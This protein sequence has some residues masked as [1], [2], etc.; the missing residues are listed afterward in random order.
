MTQSSSTPD[1]DTPAT[2]EA[3][4]Q[5]RKLDLTV[6]VETTGP[7]RRHVKI[8]IAR[9]DV[10]FFRNE[11]LA[12][13]TDKAAV[14]GFRVG[15]VPAQL[16]ER[17]YKKELADQVRQ[18]LVIQTLEQ[19]YESKLIDPIT[20]PEIDLESLLIPDEGEFQFEFDVEV[21]PEFDL[22]DLKGLTIKRPVRKITDADVD[23]SVDQFLMQIATPKIVDENGAVQ[24]DD[25]I[26]CNIV[27]RQGDNVL[28]SSEEVVVAVRPTLQFS[29]AQLNDFDKLMTGAKVGDSRT[30]TVT[31]AM[32]AERIEM[33]GEAVEVV[34]TVSQIVRPSRPE[35]NEE[36]LDEYG[37][38]SVEEL[39]DR[40]RSNLERQLT[41]E[42]RQ[43]ARQQI[44]DQITAAATWDLPEKVVLKQ[45]QNALY[46]EILEMRQ[47]GYS[48][49]E[50]QA[51]E[52]HL[53]QNAVTSTRRA[54]KEHFI[55]DRLA[56]QE[57][58]EVSDI[59]LQSEIEIMARNEGEN[60]RRVR[61][62]LQK[63]GVIENLEAQ[64][65][66]R[67]AID[68][69]LDHAKYEDVPTPTPGKN[70]VSAL[71]MAVCGVGAVQVPSED[72]AAGKIG[73]VKPANKL[74]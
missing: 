53:R 20:E 72:V 28:R 27:T 2:D 49:E 54:L 60:P 17:R 39:R 42:Q 71:N 31:V 19:L 35:L 69:L 40:V 50:I 73:D 52:N 36:L 30:A 66:E 7:C 45:V 6:N 1:V 55:L 3:A 44:Q 38:E 5:K 59:D 51:R 13:V 65:R 58:I 32:E 26:V 12:D 64:I 67:K 16:I 74:N 47:A 43:S 62:R 23:N 46:R 33:R 18:T 22:G 11:A 63:S 37:F 10:E 57:K 9:S 24:L 14:P 25:T 56:T 15:H 41:H 34:V 70:T 29:D 4:D 48:D 61:A 68:F 8:G 21:R